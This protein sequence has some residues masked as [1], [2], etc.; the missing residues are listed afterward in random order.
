MHPFKELRN[1]RTHQ[2]EYI[3]NAAFNFNWKYD[4]RIVYWLKWWVNESLIQIEN[5]SF[6]SYITSTLR[7]QQI[8]SRI[9][10]IIQVICVQLFLILRICVNCRCLA[11]ILTSILDCLIKLSGI[12]VLRDL[13]YKWWK[14]RFICTSRSSSGN[15]Q[16]TS[17]S[18]MTLLYSLIISE[19]HITDC[20]SSSSLWFL[21]GCSLPWIWFLL[22]MI[23]LSSY[24]LWF[25]L[26]LTALQIVI[27]RIC[28]IAISG[29]ILQ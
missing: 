11:F 20:I 16:I 17:S 24:S 4:I 28:L 14:F 10:F 18:F 26:L 8:L 7:T 5:Q 19:I 21:I 6:L 9:A 2:N 27:N 23:T 22:L 13:A 29:V 3:A 12:N 25:L 1:S 15:Y